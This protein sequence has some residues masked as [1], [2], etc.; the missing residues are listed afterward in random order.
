[1]NTL[2]RWRL[3]LGRFARDPLKVDLDPTAA[4]RE[5][6]L[7]FLY[8]REY[9]G[10]GIRPDPRGPGSLDPSQLSIPTWLDEVR[11]LFPGD[12]VEVMERHALDRYG[13]TE[14]LT[15]RETLSR[16]E[17]NEDLLR[18]L[19]AFRRHLPEHVLDLARRIIRRVVED[20]TRRLASQVRQA[21]SG[22][23]N[24]HRRSLHAAA[25]AFDA[26]R[27]LR[28]NLQ[29]YDVVRRRLILREPWF[30][31]RN[32]RR[33]PWRIILC[34]DQ[35]G[36]MSDSVI[37]AAVMAGILS[38]LP[39]LKMSLVAFD[40]SIVDLSGHVQDP[41]EVLMNVQ[42]G[43]GTHIA[44]ALQYC[45][46]LIDQPHRTI[47][48]LISD[49][50][51]GGPP[52]ELLTTTRRLAGAGVQLLGLAALDA[53]A[54]PSYDRAMAQRLAEAGMAIAA[55]TPSRFADWLAQVVHSR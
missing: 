23:V 32:H 39:S 17:P 29:H 48:A 45:E 33:L 19:L 51:E 46:T 16:L 13:L 14:L 21:F 41:V 28:R 31:A 55:L 34:V 42:L 43:G 8:S 37:H 53:Q 44:Q 6:A 40:T 2:E 38:G 11:E 20:I 15:D 52:S 12:V 26:R 5:T 9:Q 50:C 47:L 54:Q 25:S 27:T 10:R 18:T 22:R 49:F 30:F 24:R 4:R 36:S 3:V 35:S 1:M 7:D